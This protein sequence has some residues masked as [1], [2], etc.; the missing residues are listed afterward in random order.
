[1]SLCFKHT[2]VRILALDYY[3]LKFSLSGVAQGF[4]EEPTSRL[5][6]L[7]YGAYLIQGLVEINIHVNL[8]ATRE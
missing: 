4:L 3:G 6:E 7:A 2:C 8:L 5:N 1:M